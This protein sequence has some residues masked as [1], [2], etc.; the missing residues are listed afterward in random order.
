MTAETG[1]P[2]AEGGFAVSA[3]LPLDADAPG[4]NSAL[5]ERE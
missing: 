4:A 2:R 3:K 1:A 5:A